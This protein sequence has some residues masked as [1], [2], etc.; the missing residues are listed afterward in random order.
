MQGKVWNNA[1][2]FGKHAHLPTILRNMADYIEKKPYPWIHP[3][4][5]PRAPKVYVAKYKQLK[6][7]MNEKEGVDPPP[8]PL[9]KKGKP[10]HL[11]VRLRSC[12]AKYEI[13]PFLKN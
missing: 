11:S 5:K 8:L 9:T 1:H 12:F 3:T 10:K 2:R 4:E 6:K 13:D 7:L